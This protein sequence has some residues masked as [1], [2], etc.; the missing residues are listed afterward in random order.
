MLVPLQTMDHTEFLPT[1]F[2]ST[3]E[4]TGW[5]IPPQP[6]QNVWVTLAEATHQDTLYLSVYNPEKCTLNVSCW[7]TS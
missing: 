2:W 7:C 4:G 6:K 3:Q 5:K 1:V